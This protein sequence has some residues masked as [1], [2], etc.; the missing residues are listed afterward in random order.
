VISDGRTSKLKRVRMEV[1]SLDFSQYPYNKQD[2]ASKKDVFTVDVNGKYET[3]STIGQ[4][5][6]LYPYCHSHNRG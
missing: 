1:K 2:D 6:L 4:V 3:I 5:F